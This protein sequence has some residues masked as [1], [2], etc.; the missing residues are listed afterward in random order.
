MDDPWK[1]DRIHQ[2]RFANKSCA[3]GVLYLTIPLNIL[4]VCSNQLVDIC[5]G[6][7]FLHSLE[8]VHS[9]LK[10]VSRCFLPWSVAYVYLP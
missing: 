7:E 3:I 4:I 10:G 1:Y 5:N 9:D 6:L 2:V 8:V